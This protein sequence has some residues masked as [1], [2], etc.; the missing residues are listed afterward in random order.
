M[1]GLRTKQNITRRKD[2][3]GR[4]KEEGRRR[5]EEGGKLCLGTERDKLPEL[6]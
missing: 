6:E 2:E 4:S 5:K 3:K 1:S